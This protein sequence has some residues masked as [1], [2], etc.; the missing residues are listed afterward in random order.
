M[1]T[2]LGE[3]TSRTSNG[4]SDLAHGF[5][6]IDHDEFIK[7][8]D[9]GV[10]S[11]HFDSKGSSEAL[12]LYTRKAIPSDA[13]TAAA[14]TGNDGEMA[15]LLDAKTATENCDVMNVVTLA[16]RN[17]DTCTVVLSDYES[18]H[19]QRWMR[20]PY[21]LRMSRS[22]TLQRSLPLRH[23]GRGVGNNGKDSFPAPRIKHQVSNMEALKTYFE[24]LDD[25]K[26]ELSPI[27][28]RVAKN[29][30]IVVLVC[31]KGQSDLLMNFACSSKAKGLDIS[32]HAHDE[33]DQMWQVIGVVNSSG[34]GILDCIIHG[35]PT[36][37]AIF[38]AG[39]FYAS[40]RLYQPFFGDT[41]SRYDEGDKET[42]DAYRGGYL[43]ENNAV[44][45][46]EI[47]SGHDGDAL[48]FTFQR[49]GEVSSNRVVKGSISLYMN[50]D[51][52]CRSNT[53]MNPP[54]YGIHITLPS[55][56]IYIDSNRIV[57]A[58][59]SA[60][61]VARMDM[62]GGPLAHD[63]EQVIQ[64]P[65]TVT[66]AHNIEPPVFKSPPIASWMPRPSASRSK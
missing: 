43:D 58:G 46:N 44:R 3:S 59:A 38:F 19:M 54:T 28:K 30:A 17:A 31:N 18:F 14:V 55:D 39:L 35:P 12:I 47:Y 15:P 53:V 49:N 61:R 62:N 6:R 24:A 29:N 27:A 20:Q 33:H 65:P 13:Q 40:S 50:G 10:A 16:A 8:Y 5:A 45:N 9:Y 26:K 56:N 32:T 22:H 60:I 64:P 11:Q 2:K 7:T 23:V 66:T 63:L 21:P 36:M 41:S 51:T 42:V 34:I 1:P 25:V 57:Q 48:V 37:H 52:T 4:V